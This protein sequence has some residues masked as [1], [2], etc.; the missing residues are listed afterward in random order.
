MILTLLSP[1][2]CFLAILWPTTI[3]EDSIKILQKQIIVLNVFSNYVSEKSSIPTELNTRINSL[4]GDQTLFFVYIY[5]SLRQNFSS[6]SLLFHFCVGSRK[7]IF[8]T[9][10]NRLI[11]SYVYDPWW[12]IHSINPFAKGMKSSTTNKIGNICS[13]LINWRQN[14]KKNTFVQRPSSSKNY[15]TYQEMNIIK[16]LIAFFIEFTSF[17]LSFMQFFCDNTLW[18]KFTFLLFR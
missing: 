17:N 6:N 9:I 18:R 11:K 14:L 15:K 5:F 8:F 16:K 7:Y 4:H 12:I 13:V 10:S 1:I 2:E 3:A